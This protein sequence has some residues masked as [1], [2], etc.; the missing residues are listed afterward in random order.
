M[1]LIENMFECRHRSERKGVG[2]STG[3]CA[4]GIRREICY[5]LI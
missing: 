1:Q 5:T 4:L 3:K 2:D